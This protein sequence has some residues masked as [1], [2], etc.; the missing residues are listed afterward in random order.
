MQ[1][2]TPHRFAVVVIFDA[3]YC[4]IA[5]QG[6]QVVFTNVFQMHRNM[7]H[8]VNDSRKPP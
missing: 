4:I 3:R 2:S 5:G 1:K 7:F 6:C 8:I